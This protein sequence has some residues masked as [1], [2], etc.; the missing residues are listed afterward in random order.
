MITEPK[1]TQSNSMGGKGEQIGIQNNYYGMTYKDTKELCQDLIQCELNTYKQEAAL[2][3]KKRNNDLLKNLIE[4]LQQEKI[5]DAA[6]GEEFKNPDMQYTYLD[7][8]KAYIRLGTKELEEELTNLLVRRIKE[9]E[10]SLLQIALREAI[11]I[12]PMLLP[13]QLDALALC[14][15]IRYTR[16]TTINNIESLAQY[17]N[18]EVLPYAGFID[19]AKKESFFTHLSY[20]K[21]GNVEV[22]SVSMEKILAHTYTGLFCLGYDIKQIENY[23][24]QY[25]KLFLPCLHDS[26]KWQI[27]AINEEALKE[28][29][30]TYS[31]MTEQEKEGI[32][33]LFK[34]NIM[35]EDKVKDL[36]CK[37]NS[38][39]VQL[40]EIWNDTS[41]KNLT[42]TTVGIVLAA[43]RIKMITGENVNMDNWI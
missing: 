26:T 28:Q 2:E 21:A 8:Q 1:M 7:A 42:L 37:M 20:T 30:K 41:L 34:N 13:K 35:P 23:K 33:Q 27:N 3:A 24:K 10:R 9:R 22:T 12:V 19:E 4:K 39:Y 32:I 15:I 17:L 5:D 43:M 29:Y 18:D 11:S 14:F 31:C 36:V 25:P 16:K 40:F 6:V 38:D